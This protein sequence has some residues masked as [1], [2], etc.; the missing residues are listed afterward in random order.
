MVNRFHLYNKKIYKMIEKCSL[1][2]AIR[3]VSINHIWI[4]IKNSSNT[5]HKMGIEI[6]LSIIY[7]EPSVLH[8]FY[9]RHIMSR[10]RRILCIQMYNNG[11]KHVKWRSVATS[12]HKW[13][14]IQQF[15]KSDTFIYFPI[16]SLLMK[17][18][19]KLNIPTNKIMIN[20]K[21]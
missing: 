6:Y 18:K 1:K 4:I 9:V 8:I 17:Q 15:R 19:P 20:L 16:S 10:K 21:S 5:R 7:P 3:L 12:S 11:I 2:W 14:H 13:D